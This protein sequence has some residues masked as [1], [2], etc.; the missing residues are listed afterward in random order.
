MLL[1]RCNST[2]CGRM[3][4]ASRKM[5]KVHTDCGGQGHRARAI[6]HARL[7][8]AVFL[9]V[10]ARGVHGPRVCLHVHAFMM[11]PSQSYCVAAWF[12]A[13]LRIMPSIKPAPPIVPSCAL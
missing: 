6:E 3:A 2:S 11:V 10:R 5:E 8:T 1:V 7:S 12:S 4:T 9:C 13:C